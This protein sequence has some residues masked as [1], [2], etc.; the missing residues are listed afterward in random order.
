MRRKLASDELAKRASPAR[1][2]RLRQS[3]RRVGGVSSGDMCC[4]PRTG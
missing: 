1:S 2:S 3:E 4:S